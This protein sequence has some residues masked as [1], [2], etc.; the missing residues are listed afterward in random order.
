M[1]QATAKTGKDYHQLFEEVGRLSEATLPPQQYFS[2]LLQCCIAGTSALAGAIWTRS[3]TGGLQAAAHANLERI[4]VDTQGS[5]PEHDEILR[6]AVELGKPMILPP[7]DAAP[8]TGDLPANP[9]DHLLILVPVQMQGQAIGLL[10]VARIPEPPPGPITANALRFLVGVAH[11][12][13]IFQ[14]NHTLTQLGQRSALWEQL[15][16][17]S[18]HV[19]GSLDLTDVAYRVANEGNRLAQ[20]DRLSVAVRRHGKVAI[21]AISGVDTVEKRAQHVKLL[22]RLCERVLDWGER[23]VYRGEADQTL[24]PPVLEALDKYVAESDSRLV[25]VEPLAGDRKDRD[26]TALVLECFEPRAE[27]DALV[28][29]LNVL[30]QHAQPAL[31]N[32][33][34]YKNIPLAWL[35]RALQS[36]RDG[37]GGPLGSTLLTAAAI[38]TAASAALVCVPFPLKLDATGQLLPSERRWL[39][40]PVEGQIVRFEAGVEPGAS[41]VK[42][43]A[44]VLMHDTDLELHMLK[45]LSDLSRTQDEI[46]ALALQQKSAPTEVERADF[47]ARKK[48]KEYE[49]D[50]WQAEL[51]ALRQ[52]THA[53]E[54][55][56]GYFWLKAPLAGTILNGGFREKL[57]HRFVQPSDG[58][59]RIG[60]KEHGWE[61]ETSIPHHHL[62]KVLEAFGNR[63]ELDVDILLLSKPTVTFRGKLARAALES[64]A[65]PS[66]NEGPGAEPVVKALVRLAGPGIPES[67]RIP[68]ELLL[69]GSEVHLRIRCGDCPLG[70]SLFHGVWEFLY[71][72]VLFF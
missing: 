43:Q 71:E 2:E 62:G 3:E 39:Y 44:L 35:W 55:R 38:V 61:I 8:T 42:D 22:G 59:L 66:E 29:R 1:S 14:R 68:S 24:P 64:E 60:A 51:R 49:R 13:S 7:R 56:P 26:R 15:E 70:Y 19:H 47:A 4:G 37:L 30:G 21:E 28:E 53:D 33:V 16:S 36:L 50:R 58:L 10:E 11:H 9:S 72:K 41:V 25:I 34:A 67:E 65:Q 18:R 20:A 17:F 63:D 57:Q 31:A 12:V 45:L 48:Q 69:T 54:A 5:N 32:A 52:R 40:P 6:R 46:A 23:L 27:T